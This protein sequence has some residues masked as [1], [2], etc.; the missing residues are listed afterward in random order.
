MK[1]AKDKMLPA[2]TIP[3]TFAGA[4]LADVIYYPDGTYKKMRQLVRSFQSVLQIL[5][6]N[7]R[8]PQQ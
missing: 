7:L 2:A 3:A 4:K 8:V 1:F 5:M 6:R